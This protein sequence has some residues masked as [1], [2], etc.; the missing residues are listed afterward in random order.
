MCF[1]F[2]KG[3]DDV[4]RRSRRGWKGRDDCI[5]P[6]GDAH[7]AARGVRVVPATRRKAPR[8]ESVVDVLLRSSRACQVLRS[9]RDCVVLLRFYVSAPALS[10]RSLFS[11]LNNFFLDN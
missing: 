11:S 4:L 8:R 1:T 2:F 10:W 3:D 9:V 5:A 6:H 7:V